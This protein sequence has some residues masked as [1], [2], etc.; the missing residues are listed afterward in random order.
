M[1]VTLSAITCHCHQQAQ[2]LPR[3]GPLRGSLRGPLPGPLQPEQL[4]ALRLLFRQ[5]PAPR[6]PP[7]QLPSWQQVPSGQQGSTALLQVKNEQN[8]GKSVFLNLTT[9]GCLM[10]LLGD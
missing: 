5:L 1:D 9:K 10:V 3:P 4:S 7:Q 8:H 6:P 2:L